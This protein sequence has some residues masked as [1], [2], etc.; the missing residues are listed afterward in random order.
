MFHSPAAHIKRPPPKTAELFS[1]NTYT[2]I[3]NTDDQQVVL[4]SNIK[5]QHHWPVNV[6]MH[7]S[8]LP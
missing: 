5:S 8:D 7:R 4:C 1:I 6:L 3:G 2:I